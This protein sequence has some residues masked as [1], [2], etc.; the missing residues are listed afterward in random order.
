MCALSET[1]L[2][3][4][5]EVVGRVSGEAGGRVREGV[6]LFLSVCLL[7]CVIEW[8]EVSSRLMWVRAKI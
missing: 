4:R 8:K 5:G 2:K 7:R 6:A 3:G 1:E